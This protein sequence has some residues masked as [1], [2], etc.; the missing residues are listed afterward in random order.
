MLKLESTGH[1]ILESPRNCRGRQREGVG[2][3]LEM[4]VIWPRRRL[5]R[6]VFGSRFATVGL[7]HAASFSTNM[8]NALSAAHASGCPARHRLLSRSQGHITDRDRS[9]CPMAPTCLALARRRHSPSDHRSPSAGALGV[10]PDQRSSPRR[11]CART[12]AMRRAIAESRSRRRG[13]LAWRRSATCFGSSR[14]D[15][16]TPPGCQ[17]A[18]LHGKPRAGSVNPQETGRFRLLPLHV[19]RHAPQKTARLMSAVSTSAKYR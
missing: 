13:I 3:A 15:I 7:G 14:Q 12:A 17:S 2:Q 18:C 19:G 4:R 6:E 9:H 10:S 1:A 11:P 8:G 5:G 16:E